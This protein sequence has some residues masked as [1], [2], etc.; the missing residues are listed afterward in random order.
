M[1]AFSVTALGAAPNS[2]G[3]VQLQ[4]SA[5]TDV[6][7][8]PGV[9][10]ADKMNP[11]RVAG[12]P[13]NPAQTASVAFIMAGL[14]IAITPAQSG[15]IRIIITG[16]IENDTGGDGAQVQAAYGVGAAPVNGAAAAGTIVGNLPG[17]FLSTAVNQKNDFALVAVV[18]GLVLAT[19]IWVD[20]QFLAV[21]GGNAILTELSYTIEEF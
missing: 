3:P 21:T 15:K 16:R 11:N 14:A 10:T 19:P 18:T 20:L 7:I 17:T 5:V 8:A 1:C 12:Q 4:P 9:I 2:I 13:A 6:A